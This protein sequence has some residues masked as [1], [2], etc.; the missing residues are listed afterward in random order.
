MN[1]LDDTDTPLT[2]LQAQ[3][4]VCDLG[5]ASAELCLAEELLK[6]YEASYRNRQAW[7]LTCRDAVDRA[8]AALPRTPVYAG[9]RKADLKALY[10]GFQ[11][12]QTTPR[13]FGQR[14]QWLM[15]GGR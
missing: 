2:R 1:D 3:R 11:H 8:I 5:I 4:R 12:K 9:G 14:M 15:R 7:F 6:P 13:E 10:V